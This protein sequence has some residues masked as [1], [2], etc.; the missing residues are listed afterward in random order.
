[1]ESHKDQNQSK[2]NV[3]F[4]D[5]IGSNEQSSLHLKFTINKKR[6]H[7]QAQK[8]K[9]LAL[10][11]AETSSSLVFVFP[12]IEENQDSLINL[13]ESIFTSTSNTKISSYIHPHFT[14][15]RLAFQTIKN[16]DKVV[17]VVRPTGDLA[18]IITG[19]I[20]FL[21]STDQTKEIVTNQENS[22][23]VDIK[24]INTFGDIEEWMQS[25]DS[26]I[27]ALLKSLK[28]DVTLNIHQELLISVIELLEALDP[29]FVNSPLGFLQFFTNFNIDMQFAGSQE[30]PDH[31][32]SG[33]FSS[34]KFKHGMSVAE[35]S[36][37]A[38]KTFWRGLAKYVEPGVEIYLTLEDTIALSLETKLPAF[39]THLTR[40]IKLEEPAIQQNE[41]EPE[42]EVEVKAAAAV[43]QQDEAQGEAQEDAQEDAQD[44]AQ[45]DAQD[46]QDGEDA[47][48]PQGTEEAQDEQEA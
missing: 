23:V 14:E 43:E 36:S 27:G 44:E 19:Q 31:I 9:Q 5:E 22:I 24:S 39:G 26:F 6:A 35:D 30:L 10:N 15:G 2:L 4:G 29:V 25:G 12:C 45:E 17:L 18:D 16:Q 40:H 11:Q 7:L 33:L 37:E 13:L 20:G 34:G 46:D 42:T 8:L 3:L 48:E 21:V 47:Q 38:D 1:M 28:L 41:V 32:R